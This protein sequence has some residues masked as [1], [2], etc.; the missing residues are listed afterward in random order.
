V[1]PETVVAYFLP[2]FYFTVKRENLIRL[3]LVKVPQFRSQSKMWPYRH[4]ITIP[5]QL[6]E[7]FA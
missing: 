7:A 3:S 1:S 2:T 6:D 5:P 4:T